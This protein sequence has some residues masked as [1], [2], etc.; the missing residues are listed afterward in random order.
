M[1][2]FEPSRLTLC[3]SVL[4]DAYHRHVEFA[5]EEGFTHLVDLTDGATR[6]LLSG[7]SFEP[8]RGGIYFW[9]AENGEAY[10]GKAKV[11]RSRLSQHAVNH[12]D[13]RWAFFKYVAE[14]ERDTVEQET[15]RRA[16]QL[17]TTRNIKHA[18]MT[19]V[20][21]PLDDLIDPE[22]QA[23]FIAGGEM[24]IGDWRS[25]PE[26][27]AKQEAGWRRFQSQKHAEVAAK[28]LRLFIE[29]TLPRAAET[30]VAFWSVTAAPK[31][32]LLR[33]NAGQQ[34][35]FTVADYEGELVA[36][37]LTP[38]PRLGLVEGPIYETISY[39]SAV[40]V[41]FLSDWLTGRRLRSAR[42]LVIRLMRQ[43]QPLNSRSHCPRL[44]DFAFDL[45]RERVAGGR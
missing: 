43:S 18:L 8:R 41:D 10:V 7:R 21:R 40:P 28:A 4:P 44:I 13:L 42:E 31:H 16:D 35:V 45:D 1:N 26:L 25:H 33:L 12:P 30:E 14:H 20:H 38:Q 6:C 27:K 2:P 3:K 37:V 34:E 24:Q 23:K 9:I 39:V 29:R 11:V 17:F 5:F 32:H 36:R 19:S 22:D 15:I